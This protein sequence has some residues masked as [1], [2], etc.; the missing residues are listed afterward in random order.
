MA[1]NIKTRSVR[2]RNII[3]DVGLGRVRD[4]LVGAIGAISSAISSLVGGVVLWAP[5]KST[6]NADAFKDVF[7]SNNPST[8]YVSM[9]EPPLRSYL[10]FLYTGQDVDQ[11]EKVQTEMYDPTLN[12]GVGGKEYTTVYAFKP[13]FSGGFKKMTISVVSVIDY[14]EALGYAI[15]YAR[16]FGQ[17]PKTLVESITEVWVRKDGYDKYR[18]VEDKIL[19]YA[20][21]AKKDDA[22]GTLEEILFHEAT[23][24][25]IDKYC[26]NSNASL[27][28][29]YIDNSGNRVGWT[30]AQK[31]DKTYI[32]E[33]AKENPNREDP[34]ESFLV[35]YALKYRLESISDLTSQIIKIAIPNRIKFFDNLI[36]DNGLDMNRI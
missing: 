3:D 30:D 17:M 18:A 11:R 20:E 9:E 12:N 10:E 36:I 29:Y 13:I 21:H 14:D 28:Y 16:I 4:S 26:I 32:S 24:T 27:N 34:A 33:Y 2:M 25:G 5:K 31:L 15:K 8:S 1:K 19:I 6:E 22:D 35:Y 7:S 23:H